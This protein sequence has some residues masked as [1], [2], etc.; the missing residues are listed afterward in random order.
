MELTF[1]SD[2]GH[3]WLAVP[4]HE[5]CRVGILDRVSPYSYTDGPTLYLEEDCDA[6]LYLRALDARGEARPTI[7]EVNEPNRDSFVRSLR[8]GV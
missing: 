5:V 4:R 8:R 2:P 6:S 7:R 3:G 1:Y